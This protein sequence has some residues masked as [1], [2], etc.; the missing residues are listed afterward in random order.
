MAGPLYLYIPRGASIYDVQ[1]EGDRGQ[2][3]IQIA[4][5]QYK[6]CGQ[7]GGQKTQNFVDVIYGSPLVENGP[8]SN[9]LKSAFGQRLIAASSSTFLENQLLNSDSK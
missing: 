6:F 3:I 8:I 1:A 5:K 9:S 7:R 4:D 2:E